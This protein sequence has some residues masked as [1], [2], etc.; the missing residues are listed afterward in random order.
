MVGRPGKGQRRQGHLVASCPANPSVKGTANMPR[1]DGV[2]SNHMPRHTVTQSHTGSHKNL[3]PPRSGG[4]KAL[5][6]RLHTFFSLGFWSFEPD[7]A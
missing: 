2:A 5:I 7:A 4:H 3:M 1:G 6:S